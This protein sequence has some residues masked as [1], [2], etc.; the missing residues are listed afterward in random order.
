MKTVEDRTTVATVTTIAQTLLSNPVLKGSAAAL[1]I[2][3]TG[4]IL[5]FAMFA[6]AARSMDAHDFGTLAV[7][8]NAMSFLAVIAAC[9]QETLIVRS[10]DEY[11]GS[12]RPALA[13][14]ALAFSVKVTVAAAVLVAIVVAA[15]WP[16][17]RPS[18]PL[19]LI[20][21]ACAFLLLQ[22]FMNFSAQFSRVAGGVVFG[23]TPREILW[24]LV[25]VLVILAH[26]HSHT[27]FAATEFFATAAA[28]LALSIV[29]QQIFVLRCLPP[30]VRQSRAAY[31][32][33]EWLPR[34]V[35][36]WIAAILD[37]SS[38]YL[39]VIV[40]GL[41]LG[42]TA[43]AFFFVATRITNVFAMITGSITAYAT[44]QIS[45]L[46]HGNAKDE[47][48]IILRSLA[49][50]S[51]AL[52][53]GVF[54]VIAFGG[55]LLLWI[56]GSV[57]VSAYPALLILAAGAATGAL[58]GPASYLLLLTG[59]EGAYPRIMG[60]GLLARVALISI[61]GP[62]LGLMG[63]AI[64]WSVSAAGVALALVIACRRLTG[65]DPSVLSIL[66]R[67]R[68]AEPALKGSMPS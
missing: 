64:A 23:E 26:L 12:D 5:G 56:F 40:V 27:P 62:W 22:A 38:Q 39:E 18:M 37:T 60:C 29:L 17:I 65:V 19:N 13:R 6:L 16:L 47:L 52:A 25:V 9:G 24:R 11:C 66:T 3:F 45:G 68:A 41:F 46:F 59:N 55:K 51:A 57:Y 20:L 63:A 33:A 2:K 8:F 43:A 28:A 50:I 15:A 49:M 4:S 48:Q 42:P 7:I 31:D 34:S 36:M 14:G 35:R 32:L 30:S 61:L 21:A 53:A 58:A 10:W 67:L 54:I 1:A 44:T